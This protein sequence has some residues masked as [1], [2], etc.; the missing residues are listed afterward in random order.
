MGCLLVASR[1]RN[2]VCVL[3]LDVVEDLLDLC[4]GKM[5]RGVHCVGMMPRGVHC[6]ELWVD[7]GRPL[8][9]LCFWMFGFLV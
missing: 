2:C 4:V 3:L 7:K 8:S 9:E 5:P 1:G 6:L